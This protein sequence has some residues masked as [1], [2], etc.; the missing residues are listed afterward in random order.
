[1]AVFLGLLVGVAG[2]SLNWL[3]QRLNV[4]L[5]RQAGGDLLTAARQAFDDGDLDTAIE[6][7][8]QVLAGQPG[9]AGAV[10]L[11]AR[12]LVYR[13][14]TDY[15]RGVD[16][17]S[18]LQVTTEALRYAPDDL[19]VLAA[20]AFALQA[21][22]QQAQAADVA[23][24]VLDVT[25]NHGLARTALGLAYGGAGSFEISLRENLQAVQSESW[26]LD[27]QRALA[28]SYSDLGD[29]ESAIT[30]VDRAIRQ[31]NRLLPLYFERALYALQIGDADSATSAYFQVLVYDPDNVKAR[32]RLCELSSLL[33]ERD[34]AIRYCQQVTDL[35]PA[36]ADGW[37]QLGREYFLQGSFRAA[38]EHLHRC[39]SLQV[40]QNIPA[41]A[42]R[43]E[44]WYLQG[45]AAE[46]LGDCE[47]LLATYNEFRAMTVDAAVQQ[48]WTYPPEGPPGCSAPQIPP[49]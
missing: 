13:S 14:Y 47:S 19:D 12:A 6:L 26:R 30:A 22:G 49:P 25:P 18:A 29:Y 39:S 3:G 38:Q 15:D 10:E 32:L 11:L 34:A 21:T 41:E 4:A 43:F 7:S 8:R 36:W 35:A 33:R 48:T 24:R 28:I 40:M 16:R 20:H 1:L 42:R 5:S 9:D 45:Q 27:S 31:N 23:R 44:C 17:D 37:Y 46:I 2:L